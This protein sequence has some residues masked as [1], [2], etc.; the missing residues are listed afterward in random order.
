MSGSG[1]LVRLTVLLDA[2]QKMPVQIRIPAGRGVNSLEKG[3][4]L[5]GTARW[6]AYP[7]QWERE[8]LFGSTFRPV[9]YEAS[10]KSWDALSVD[11]SGRKSRLDR[12]AGDREALLRERVQN[13]YPPDVAGL[14]GAMV[15]SDTGLLPPDLLQSFQR[16]GVYHL[17]SVSGEHMAL[18][19]LFLTG[20]F[21]I[22]LRFFPVSPLRKMVVRFPVTLFPG[23]LAVPVLFSYLFLIGSPLPAVRAGVAFVLVMSGR[24]AGGPRSW[25][26]ILGLSILVL[27]FLYPE[28]PLSLSVDLSLMA[29]WGLALSGRRREETSPEA[30]AEGRSGNGIREHLETGAIVMLTTLPLLWFSLGK[31]D[32]VGIVSNMFAVPLAGDVFLPL[33]FLSILV[34][35]VV[36]GGFPLLNELTTRVGEATVGLVEFFSRVPFGQVTLPALSPAALLLLTVLVLFRDGAGEKGEPGRGDRSLK[37]IFCT[38]AFFI[39]LFGTVFKNRDWTPVRAFQGREGTFPRIPGW[40]PQI[41]WK[42]LG[43]LFSAQEPDNRIVR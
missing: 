40:E 23:W 9:L 17:L 28:A 12:E 33:G 37:A 15:L 34:L 5:T 18:L 32:W 24:L 35:W 27:G 13:V 1:Q 39:V 43:W 26:D 7:G 6:E 4:C 3:D 10:L 30:L 22:F 38:V 14:L 42:N 36:P 31:A 19:A 25:P 8:H 21:T 16:S 29:L 2:V 11:T 41:E 20:V